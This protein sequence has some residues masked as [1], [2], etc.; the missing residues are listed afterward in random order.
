MEQEQIVETNYD[1]LYDELTQKRGVRTWSPSSTKE[2][3]SCRLKHY[4]KYVKGWRI[5]ERSAALSLGTS[6]HAAAE[7]L[8]RL[9]ALNQEFTTADLFE[10]FDRSW[11]QEISMMEEGSDYKTQ[12]ELDLN[13]QKGLDLIE[14]H[15]N[16]RIRKSYSPVLY[17]PPFSV[18][19]A[20]AVELKV[21]VPFVHMR[22][23]R[24]IND[25]YRITGFIDV[26][27]VAEKSTSHFDPGDLMVLDYKTLGREWD[28]FTI[29]T[30]LQLLMYAYAMRF[31]LRNENWFPHLKKD[32]EDLVGIVCLLKQRESKKS[33]KWGKIKNYIIRITDG[34]ID[35]LERLLTRC[36]DTLEECGDQA[37]NF[38]PNPT[39]DNCRYCKFKE[40]CLMVRRGGR[41]EDV[42]DWGEANGLR[43]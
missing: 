18:Q 31:I 26:V 42:L 36:I 24:L 15:F 5:R 13:R 30:N 38:I 8:N 10:E 34:E 23:G 17:V 37:E 19:Q 40:P 6:F 41:T 20:P 39:P 9:Q 29:D 35:Y 11:A 25:K 27:S 28:Q 32:Q 22:T 3:L 7:K 21:D 33:E 4:F 14:K 43:R 16:S 12:G 1:E 2:F